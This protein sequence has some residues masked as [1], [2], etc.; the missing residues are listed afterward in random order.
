MCACVCECVCY[1]CMYVCVSVCVCVCAIMGNCLYVCLCVYVCVV[2]K[3]C[4]TTGLS[5]RRC[6][7]LFNWILNDGGD[8]CRSWMII[9]FYYYLYWLFVHYFDVVKI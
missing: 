3:K 8:C 9:R 7:T 2:G 1:V 4:I 6:S 5:R